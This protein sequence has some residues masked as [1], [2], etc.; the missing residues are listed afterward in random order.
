MTQKV[1]WKSSTAPNVVGYELLFSDTGIDGDYSVLTTVLHQ[2]PGPNYEASTASFFYNDDEVSYRWY[3]VRVVDQY[4][5][6]AEDDYPTP[7]K[8]GN[9][10]VD[11]PS[12]H[13]VSL[14]HNY[15]APNAYQ[16]VTPDGDPVEQATIRVYKKDLWDAGNTTVVV[17]ITKTD[18]NGQWKVPVPVEPGITYTLV[19][20]KENEYGPDTVEL[21]V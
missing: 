7:F 3:R 15:S 14:D 21:T 1:S 8:A 2:I 5:N 17:G 12:L 10:P 6:K 18:E 11:V 13:F 4:G 9:N 20:H 16:Y 19:F